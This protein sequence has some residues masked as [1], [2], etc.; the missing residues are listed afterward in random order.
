ML[1]I[2]AFLSK[3]KIN[4]IG[5]FAGENIKAGTIVYKTNP[6]L[7]LELTVEQFKQIDEPSKKL[8]QHYGYQDKETTKWHLAFDNI[9]FLNHSENGNLT[10]SQ[11]YG[12]NCLI[13]KTN[14]KK[15]EELLQDYHEFENLR[16][17][18][19]FN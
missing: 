6:G 18:I 17:E 13:A 7:D 16:P 1:L 5:L 8:I 3:S 4:G 9:R 12:P 19:S 2:K 10:K 14:I 15:G 11:V